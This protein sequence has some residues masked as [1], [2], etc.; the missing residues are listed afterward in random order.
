MINGKIDN[1]YI[2]TNHEKQLKIQ[3]KLRGGTEMN[4]TCL[5]ARGMVTNTTNRHKMKEIAE[6]SKNQ[7]M[8]IYTETA[9]TQQ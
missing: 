8:M 1:E 7:H 6:L 9:C 5:N 3:P 2:V 4:I